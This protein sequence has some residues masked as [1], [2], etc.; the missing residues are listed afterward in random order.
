MRKIVVFNLLS[1]DGFFEGKNH[2]INWHQVDEEFNK[3]AVDHTAKFDTI[4]FGSR[5]YKL[6]EDFWPSAVNNSKFSADDQRIAKIIDDAQKYVFSKKIKEVKWKNSVLLN[7]IDK[8]EVEKIKKEKGKDIVI[9]GSGT[10]VSQ[11]SDL[12]LIDEYRFIINPLALGEGTSM[13][14]GVSKQLNFKLISTKKFKNGNILLTYI[15]K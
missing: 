15:P 1:I 3:F 12:G 6:F 5:T 11:F 7:E 8:K 14:K 10:I 2:D 13:F 9:F 4:I